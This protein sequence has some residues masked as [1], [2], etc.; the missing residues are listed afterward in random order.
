MIT[1]IHDLTFWDRYRDFI[2]KALDKTCGELDINDIYECLKKETMGLVDIHGRAACVVE[3][4]TYPQ[5]TA[6]RVVALGGE[7]MDEWLGDLLEYLYKWA[8]ENNMDRIEHMG[9]QGWVRKLEPYGYKE[10]YTFMTR[11][12]DG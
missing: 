3:F 6:L 5:I 12:V 4:M 7:D 11:E 9:R 2:Q 1:F 10:R 8:E